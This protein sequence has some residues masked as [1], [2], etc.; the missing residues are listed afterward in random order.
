MYKCPTSNIDDEPTLDE[1]K[2]II[3]ERKADIAEWN[4]RRKRKLEAPYP[5]A[6]P[7]YYCDGQE[8]RSMCTYCIIN[9]DNRLLDLII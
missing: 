4:K 5:D 6:S 1:L 2:K 8:N 3:D 9:A 7:C